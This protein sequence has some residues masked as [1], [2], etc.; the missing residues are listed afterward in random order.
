MK[1]TKLQNADFKNTTYI[2]S[3]DAK[4]TAHFT[5]NELLNEELPW[6][7][8]IKNNKAFGLD[9]IPANIWK[10]LKGDGEVWLLELYNDILTI[11]RM[12]AAW[13]KSVLE[14]F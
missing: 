7:P 14:S 13:R 8:E 1:Y 6:Q 10:E 4:L 3:R 9:E 5:H 11:E 2:K 12:S